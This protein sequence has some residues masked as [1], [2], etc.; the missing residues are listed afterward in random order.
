MDVESSRQGCRFGVVLLAAGASRR[1]GRP[2]LLLPWGGTTVLEHLITQWRELG[3]AQIAV[4]TPPDHGAMREALEPWLAR[5]IHAVMNPDPD[6]GMFSSIQ[7]ASA[8]DGWR[9]ELT[10]W[11]ISL[12]DQPHLLPLTLRQL[13]AAGCHDPDRI[14]QPSRAGRG[15]HPVWM[16][17]RIFRELSDSSAANLKMF[18][19]GHSEDRRLVAMADTG[20]DL[21]MDYPDDY[22]A[23]CRLANGGAATG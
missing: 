11:L 20:L 12:G 16:P 22:E 6:R 18:L 7:C 21:D 19:A 23:A 1:M 14:V 3:A 5:G 9:P 17:R 13:V 15:R 2:K 4:V 10:H 8:W